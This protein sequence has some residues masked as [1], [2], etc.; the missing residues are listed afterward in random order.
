MKKLLIL[1]VGLACYACTS[2]N[3]EDYYGTVDCASR[4]V[5]YEM[6]IVPIIKSNCAIPGCHAPGTYLPDWTKYE[7]LVAHAQKIKKYTF[8]GIM[9]PSYSGKSLTIE[10]VRTISCWIDAGTPNN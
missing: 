4:N 8:E 1:I 3:V 6:D 9:P 5:S 7:N 2:D 10:E